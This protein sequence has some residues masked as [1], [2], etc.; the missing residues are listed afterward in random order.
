MRWGTAIRDSMTK[1]GRRRR[2]RFPAARANAVRPYQAHVIGTVPGS[3][4]LLAATNCA[5]GYNEMR[6]I[7][8]S[9]R[10]GASR[11]AVRQEVQWPD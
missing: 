3:R 4:R 10:R 9:D 6:P 7:A 2:C 8:R 5:M 11:M 1:A